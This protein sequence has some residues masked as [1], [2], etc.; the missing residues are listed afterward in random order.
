MSMQVIIQENYVF[1]RKL[2]RGF[3][4]TLSFNTPYTYHIGWSKLNTHYYGVRYSRRCHPADLWVNYFTSSKIVKEF[5]KE[6]GEPDIVEVRKTF[7]NN[8]DAG[9]WEL[10][11]LKKLDAANRSN[12]LNSH[13][14][15]NGNFKL[16]RS[17]NK[18]KKLTSEEF[19]Y[20]RIRKRENKWWNNGIK[21]VFTKNPPDKTYKRGRLYFI[22]NG[23]KKGTDIQRGKIWINNDAIEYMIN[24]NNSIPQ[25]FQKGRLNSIKKQWKGKHYHGKGTKWWNNGIQEKMSVIPPDDSY[26]LGR[27][28]K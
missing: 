17:K 16:D 19:D 18:Y 9:M 28:S 2:K 24:P 7:T 5:K 10:M 6:Y 8:D 1:K 25:G 22:N 3:P 12:W 14:G 13:N 21:Q 15:N 20:K 27:L 23:F 26:K 11:V 4:T